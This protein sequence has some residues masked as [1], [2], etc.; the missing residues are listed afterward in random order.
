MRRCAG[1]GRAQVQST[2]DE[3]LYTTRLDRAKAGI[4]AA[5]AQRIADEIEGNAARG[6]HAAAGTTGGTSA[7]EVRASVIGPPE[8]PW[9]TLLCRP[10]GD[11]RLGEAQ[12]VPSGLPVLEEGSRGATATRYDTS[13]ALGPVRNA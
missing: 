13:A 6:R 4:S 3:N 11:P 10:A 1:R 5:D 8:S 12:N 2:W 9:H 7:Q